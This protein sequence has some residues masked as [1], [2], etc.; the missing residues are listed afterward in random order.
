[1]ICELLG[2]PGADQDQF[3]LWIETVLGASLEESAESSRAMADY[4]RHLITAKRAEP[5]DDLLSALIEA[6]EEGDRLSE[7]ELVA[8]IFQLVVAGHETSMNFIGN[9]LLSLLLNP[10]QHQ[11]LLADRGLLPGALEEFLRFEGSV[12]LATHRFTAEPV[13]IAGTVIPAGEVVLV[14]LGSANRDPEQFEDP[15]RLNIARPGGAHGHLAFGHGIHYC[16][17]AQLARMEGE[18]VFGRLLDR[19][20]RMRLAVEPGRLRWRTSL[21]FRGVHELPV[22]LD[23]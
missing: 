9:G 7:P 12:N 11:A 13:E 18:V 16:L 10:G 23:Q 21:L 14:G 4:M 5:A 6:T 19:F 2:I 1:V 8:T 15:N 17:G 22:I 20:P 3:R